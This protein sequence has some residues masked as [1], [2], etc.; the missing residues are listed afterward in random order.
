MTDPK[1]QWSVFPNGDRGV[2]YVVR[3]DDFEELR[4]GKELVLHEIA[5]TT[6]VQAPKREE[7]TVS[8]AAVST[9]PKDEQDEINEVLKEEHEPVE[10]VEI[11]PIH[12][13]AMQPREGKFGKFYSHGEKTDEGWR[14]CSGKG[15]K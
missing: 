14:N 5:S 6:L 8:T 1:F 3:A 15:W 11:C 4:K 9:L 12:N 7:T 13:V 2:Q 10:D